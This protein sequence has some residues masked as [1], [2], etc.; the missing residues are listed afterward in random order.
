MKAMKDQLKMGFFSIVGIFAA[1]TL[2]TVLGAGYVKLVKWLG[3]Y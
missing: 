3:G 1:L 2:V